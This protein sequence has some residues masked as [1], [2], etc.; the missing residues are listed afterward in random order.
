MRDPTEIVAIALPVMIAEAISVG[1]FVAM[2]TVWA[3]VWCG[4]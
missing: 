2:L 1:L 3:A 4:A